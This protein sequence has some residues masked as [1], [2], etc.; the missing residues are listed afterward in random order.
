VLILLDHGTSKGSPVRCL[1]T[2]RLHGAIEGSVRVSRLLN[3]AARHVIKTPA[4]PT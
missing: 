4:P 2:H 1:G 3:T